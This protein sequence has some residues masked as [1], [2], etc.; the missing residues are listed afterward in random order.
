MPKLIFTQEEIDN[1]VKERSTH[2]F[3]KDA[4]EISE[5]MDVHASGGKNPDGTLT[6]RLVKL[7][8]ERRP[9][10][11]LEVLEYRKKIFVPKTKPTFSKIF[12]SLQK[13]RRSSDWSIRYEG[14]FSKI[15]EGETLEEYADQNYPG[16]T[17]LT[18]WVFTLMLRK[19]LIDPNAVVYV[20]PVYT[21]VQV[22][23][24]LQPIA[25]VFDSKYVV[26]FVENDFAVLL[27][28]VGS[29]YYSGGK[30]VKGKRFTICTTQQI[31]T[32]DQVNG[33]G[34]FS[35]TDTYDHGLGTL[36]AFKLKGVI[37]EQNADYYLYESRI[38]G[39][40][41]ELDEAIREYSDLQAAKVLHIYPERWEFTQN[42]CTSC[43]GTGI[44]RN[45]LY[46]GVGCGCEADIACGKC[47]NGYV[48]AGPYSKILVRPVSNPSLEG[49]AQI[50]TPPAGYVEKDV[51]I[52]KV[53]EESVEGH[54]Y[55]ALC[56]INFEFLGKS[57][58]AQS[59]VAKAY[60]SDEMNN[61]AHSIGEDIV[62]AMDNIYWLI[63]LWRYRNLYGV[64]EIAQ[65]V[66]SVAVPEKFDILSAAHTLEEL[67]SAKESKTNP[68]ITSAL[69]IDYATR[70]FNADPQVRDRVQLILKLDPLPNITEDDKMSRLSNKGVT[71]EA[72]VISS[73]IQSFV[74]RAIDK[75]KEFVDMDLEKQKGIMEKYAAEVIESEE[76]KPPPDTGLDDEGK[77]IPDG[78]QMPLNR[79]QFPVLNAQNAN[80]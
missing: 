34:A 5:M 32:Y 73:N 38:A 74:Q 51:E 60:D 8:H 36:P 77:P 19:Y 6:N 26:D 67:K 68:V 33:K 80:A 28:P 65:M 14:E 18:N 75:E 35:L 61:T 10:E 13:I 57:P 56:A 46:T 47:T 55:S 21:D 3:Y 48:V 7:L 2:V 15:A 11:P 12:S 64:D 25:Q 37:I 42:E 41:P 16:F 66:P 29:T 17:S 58:L 49:V 69:E 70:R 4:V 72:Y 45:P 76:I 27:N 71:L 40:L 62:S 63:A 78:N 24:Y 54:I 50:P 44:R 43:K 22:N 30:P 53:M 39:I 20:A 79:S 9:N 59:G 31:L 52:V 23:E 1:Y